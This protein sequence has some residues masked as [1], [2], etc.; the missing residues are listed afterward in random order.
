MT[1]RFEQPQLQGSRCTDCCAIT[2]PVSH[3]CIVCGSASQLTV[4]LSLSGR[5]ESRTR[6]GERIV[7]EILLDDGPR[8]MGWL[9]ADQP[10]EIGAAVRFGS[11]Q[12]QLGFVCDV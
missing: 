4:Q 6:V 10:A 3:G 12:S 5:I 7:C 8:I 1:S 2:F 9:A 11:S